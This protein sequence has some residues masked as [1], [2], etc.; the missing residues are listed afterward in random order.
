MS[1]LRRAVAL[2]RRPRRAARCSSVLEVPVETPLQSKLDVS[3]LPPHPGRR[4]RDRPRGLR[5][6]PLR[7][8]LAPAAEPAPLEHRLQV[9]EPDR[10]PLQDALEKALE[11]IGEGG[12]YT[13]DEKEQYRLEADRILQDA[14]VLAQDRR[15]VPAAR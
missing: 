4:L 14:G 8:D 13:K 6:G 2:A 15:G 5:R 10:P 12:S 3:R 9:L 11:K 1:A 7:G